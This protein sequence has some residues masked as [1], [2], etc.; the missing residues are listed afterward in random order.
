M[1]S[2]LS[3]QGI[4]L[5]GIEHPNARSVVAD[6][7]SPLAGPVAGRQRLAPADRYLARVVD[8]VRSASLTVSMVA[9]VFAATADNLDVA[10]QEMN[11]LNVFPIADG[12]TGTNMAATMRPIAA[13]ARRVADSAASGSPEAR[14]RDDLTAQFSRAVT[15][16]G[17][18][19]ARGNSGLILS[20]FLTGFASSMSDP[21]APDGALGALEGALQGA[22]RNA[23]AQARGAVSNPVE[24]TMLT[25]ADAVVAAVDRLTA[26]EP[27]A[28][29]EAAADPDDTDGDGIS[30]RP[31]MVWDERAQA[32]AIGRFGWKANVIT[33]EQQ[34]A[35][36][37]N[38]DIGITSSLNPNDDCTSTQVDCRDAP[39]GAGPET[40]EPELT[41]SRLGSVTF[42]NRTLSVPAMRDT[43]DNAVRAGS[44]L[45][46]DF[47]C[48][49]CHTPTHQTGPSDVA[50]LAD[51]TIHPYTDLLLH[52]MGPG[53]A[54]GRPDFAA[55]GDEWRTPPLWGL[56]LIDDV[57]GHRF[58]LHDGRAR[59][60]EEAVLW[61]G[62]EGEAAREAFRLASA[63]D[64]ASLVAFLEAL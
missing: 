15:R 37:F 30:G 18:R 25:V 13:A 44:E 41:D 40:G 29:L 23:A 12:D 27:D 46:D 64:R 34:V 7:G 53:L 51:Q 57:N 38:G 5:I 11:R 26:A 10:V 63:D 3:P 61:H 9:D 1:S 39:S 33:V 36:A 58:L 56:G 19:S 42:Y 49:S 16:A 4:G 32:L 28:A 21:S 50:T 48:A 55:S 31:N 14:D 60:I 35:G 59:T 43:N 22:L 20:Q 8:R 47:G 2:E 54:D 17:L 62:G 52:D 24:G 45:F 6:H